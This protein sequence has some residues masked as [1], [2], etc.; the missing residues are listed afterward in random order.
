MGVVK[1]SARFKI[2]TLGQKK[3]GVNRQWGNALAIEALLDWVPFSLQLA[4][5]MEAEKWSSGWRWQ[6]VWDGNGGC[7]SWLQRKTRAFVVFGFFLPFFST[8]KPACVL[9]LWN[10]KFLHKYTRPFRYCPSCQE[11]ETSFLQFS[12]HGL[13]VQWLP[14]QSANYW[15]LFG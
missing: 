15:W 12:L 7:Q 5:P 14:Q 11:D 13:L 10:I 6:R 1:M 3:E 2:K 8:M 9:L 4:R